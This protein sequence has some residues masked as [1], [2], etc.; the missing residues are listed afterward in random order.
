M[1]LTATSSSWLNVV[2]R[3]F[4]ELIQNWLRR[5]V[6]DLEELIMAIGDHIDGHNHKPFIWTAKANDIL[7][8]EA[9]PQ[10][11]E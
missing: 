11:T 7:K 2:E 4:R 3:F 5:G 1:H 10:I 6:S 9:S 8:G